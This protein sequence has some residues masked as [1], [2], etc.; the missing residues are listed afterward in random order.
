MSKA[1]VVHEGQRSCDINGAVVQE[2]GRHVEP[3]TRFFKPAPQHP[4]GVLR[5]HRE[6]SPRNPLHDHAVSTIGGV[7]RDRDEL[8][9]AWPSHDSR[10]REELV[11]RVAVGAQGLEGKVL[12]H[13]GVLLTHAADKDPVCPRRRAPVF[14]AAQDLLRWADAVQWHELAVE[15]RADLAVFQLR[16]RVP[17]QGQ[18]AKG[19]GFV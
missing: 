7:L 11:H 8:R 17:G 16:A 9:E 19:S 1:L 5:L 15:K 4:E 12:Q 18:P 14:L 6:R 10:H 2:R 13:K 3:L